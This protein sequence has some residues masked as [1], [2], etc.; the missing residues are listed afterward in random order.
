MD[1]DLCVLATTYVCQAVT[2]SDPFQKPG[3]F[4]HFKNLGPFS[5]RRAITDAVEPFAQ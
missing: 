5:F 4:T 1:G 2:S 3:P